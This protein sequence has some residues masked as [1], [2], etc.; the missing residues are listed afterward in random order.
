MTHLLF[1]GFS[2]TI[3]SVLPKNSIFILQEEIRK[4]KTNKQAKH[5]FSDVHQEAGTFRIRIR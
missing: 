1:V 2:L 3:R 4:M 5:L